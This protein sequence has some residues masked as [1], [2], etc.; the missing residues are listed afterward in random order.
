M[1]NDWRFI[2]KLVVRRT[3]FPFEML[4]G[5]AFTQ[6]CAQVDDLLTAEAAAEQEKRTLL[7]EHFPAMVNYAHKEGDKQGLKL[8]SRYRVRVAKE[9]LMAS[10]VETIQQRWPNSTFATSIATLAHR[11]RQVEQLRNDCQTIFS[12]E[13][14]EKRR[15]LQTLVRQDDVAEA[16]FISNPDVFENSYHAFVNHH[17]FEQRPARLKML[18][19]RFML[20]LQRF[21]AKNDTASFFG[22][23]NYARFDWEQEEAI[24]LKMLPGKY[25]KRAVFYSFWMVETLAECIAQEEEIRPYLTPR[26]H[27]LFQRT[28]EG[29]ASLF[30]GGKVK[31]SGALRRLIEEIDGKTSLKELAERRGI[32]VAELHRQLQSLVQRQVLLLALEIPSTIFNPFAYLQQFVQS[33]PTENA[34]R[35]K[36]LNVLERFANWISAFTDADLSERVRISREMEQAFT[37]LTG[38]AARRLAGRAYAD[39]TLY[40]EECAGTMQTFVLGQEFYRNFYRRL[41][42]VLDLNA[43][44]G[45][46]LQAHYQKIGK[47]L[48]QAIAGKNEEIPYARFIQQIRNWQE[49]GKLVY[50]DADLQEFQREFREIV[51]RAHEKQGGNAARLGAENLAPLQH[52]ARGRALHISPD[53]M[54]AARDL[55]ALRSGEYQLVL[56]ETH[57]FISMWG[58]QFLFDPERQRVEAEVEE[59]LSTLPEY[60][61]LTTLL[62]TRRHKGLLYEA[63]PGKYIQF[64]GMPSKRARS[65][66]ELSDLVVRMQGDDLALVHKPTGDMLS[67]YHSGDENLHLWV[68]A[69]PRVESIPVEFDRHTPRIEINNVVYQ[70][71]HWRFQRDELLEID[72]H[73]T[74]FDVFLKM[75]QAQ[76]K[77]GLPRYLFVR[78]PGETKP[79]FLDFDNF[80]LLEILYQ[81]LKQN[82]TLTCNEMLPGP[83]QLW[84]QDQEGSYCLEVRGTAF[85]PA[86]HRRHANSTHRS[87]VDIERAGVAM[88][89]VGD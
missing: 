34:A 55:D 6:S 25:T 10:E 65:V 9:Q 8:L 72:E 73:D 74:D 33:L 75:R 32:T 77:H 48:F 58:S 81:Q 35:E 21:A 80:F 89:E 45:E 79:C 4:E 31:L 60:E 53:L 41:K 52:Y 46:M 49:A 23:M 13:L 22:P 61:H 76:R 3:G 38:R 68:F 36:W 18:E 50:E 47:W 2:S 29:V 63:F 1:S 5:L 85:R 56:G 39:R 62:H 26:L 87:A 12:Q 64:L 17:E 15:H 88:P 27:P 54:F 24:Q 66:L 57:Q 84:L 20:Y 69:P 78:V 67:L 11:L 37:S 28:P 86:V 42:P 59:I 71:E 70:R 51:Q 44:Y 43:V 83:E 14:T 82:E 7:Q 16:V 40:Y 19:R 30:T